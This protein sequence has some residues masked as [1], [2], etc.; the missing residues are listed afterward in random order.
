M[1]INILYTIGRYWPTIGG[2]ELHTRELIGNIT[3]HHLA[4]VACLRNDNCTDWLY[5]FTVNPQKKQQPYFD[6]RTEV[7]V[8]RL[9]LLRR[10]CLKRK[11][12]HYFSDEAYRTSCKKMLG[13]LFVRE[14]VKIP[15]SFDLVHNVMIGEEFFS[16]ASL[17]YAQK[18]GIPFVFTPI[19][20]PDGW[21]GEIFSYLYS[22][23]DALIAMTEVEKTFL[24]SQGA[25]PEKTHVV[26]VGPLIRSLS[27]T[28]DIKKRLSISGPLILF[29]GAK[30]PYK[31]IQQMLEAA[32]LVWSNHPEAY[33]IFAGPRS[34]HSKK[35]FAE[36]NNP[37]II[38]LGKISDAEKVNLLSGCDIFCMPSLCES[39]GMVYLEAWMFRK[40]VLAADTETSR[41]FIENHHDA[42]L[43]KQEASP[44][45]KA[46]CTL[47]EDD[48]LRRK[49]GENGYSKVT[50]RYTWQKI[51]SKV[52]SA[53]YSAI[54]ASKSGTF[55]TS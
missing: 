29:L 6:H 45:A 4:K 5:G 46:I 40:P 31:G 28:E 12:A 27:P 16:L 50:S 22:N 39:F 49:L 23:S 51:A 20:H 37:R 41:C 2:G 52:E 21:C 19:S 3:K 43:V 35:L 15:G 18:H 42:L 13:E 34:D 9:G 11:L 55:T 44:I 24:V 47:I 36:Q 25:H 10:M 32:P 38:E 30:H 8:I 7:R 1:K 26:G 53:Y 17:Y 48:G 54:Y 33:F 14:L